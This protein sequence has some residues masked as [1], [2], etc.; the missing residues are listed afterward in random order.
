MCK[1][2][3]KKGR[4]RKEKGGLKEREEETGP[5]GCVGGEA[6]GRVTPEERT[7]IFRFKVPSHLCPV[8]CSPPGRSMSH[9]EV[10]ALNRD[11]ENHHSK[12]WLSA[13]CSHQLRPQAPTQQNS[14]LITEAQ[15]TRHWT[16]GDCHQRWA[17][18]YCVLLHR[19]NSSFCGTRSTTMYSV[20]MGYT[21]KVT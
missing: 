18:T 3:R 6:E 13:F 12:Q 14:R 10:L 15:R 8:L 1:T 20:S 5:D 19:L 2:G 16:E 7:S 11:K 21:E 4:N 17:L 9:L